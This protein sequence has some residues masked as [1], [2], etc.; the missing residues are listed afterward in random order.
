MLARSAHRHVLA[1]ELELL[2]AASLAQEEHPGAVDG[3][4]SQEAVAGEV[5]G[6]GG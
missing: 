2:G 5:E 6:A 1:L 3:P 4:V